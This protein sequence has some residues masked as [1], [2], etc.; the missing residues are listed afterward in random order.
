MCESAYLFHPSLYASYKRVVI[1]CANWRL[2][3][4]SPRLFPLSPFLSIL[5]TLFLSLSFFLSPSSH[6]EM[7][8]VLWFVA[9]VKMWNFKENPLLLLTHALPLQHCLSAPLFLPSLSFFLSYS[10]LPYPKLTFLIL[11]CLSVLSVS[12]LSPP[13]ICDAILSSSIHP[14][15]SFPSILW[16]S[17]RVSAVC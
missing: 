2:R 9:E 7:F 15:C 3:L 16:Q 6:A 13:S 17:C 8:E 12:F 11:V 14:S 10:V 4:Q 5:L 1:I